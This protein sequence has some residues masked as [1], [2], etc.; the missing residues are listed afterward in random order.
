M[1]CPTCNGTRRIMLAAGTIRCRDCN[2]TGSILGFCN[3]CGETLRPG[4][5]G[6]DMC[7]DCARDFGGASLDTRPA[8]RAERARVRWLNMR[9]R[10]N[11]LMWQHRRNRSHASYMRIRALLDS[12]NRAWSWYLRWSQAAVA[13]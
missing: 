10:I 8:D 1:I 11:F 5:D 6:R 4:I 12:A 9:T 7:E 2:D 13:C 3:E